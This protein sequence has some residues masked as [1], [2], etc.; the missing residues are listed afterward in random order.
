MAVGGNRATRR[1]HRTALDGKTPGT[2]LARAG[3]EVREARSRPRSR[4]RH[5][6]LRR[7]LQESLNT[8]RDGVR[9]GGQGRQLSGQPTEGLS[10]R[11]GRGAGPH[12]QHSWKPTRAHASEETRSR[13]TEDTAQKDRKPLEGEGPGLQARTWIQGP[14]SPEGPQ[15]FNKPEF[16]ERC[17]SRIPG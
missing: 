13:T 4:D 9:Q 11:H 15:L 5:H 16:A 7:R 17:V 6:R 2:A 12:A 14:E 8:M 1:S 10:S 3:A